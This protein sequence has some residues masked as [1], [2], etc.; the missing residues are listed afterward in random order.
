MNK[1]QYYFLAAILAVG[2]LMTAN[3]VLGAVTPYVS[4]NKNA[5]ITKIRAVELYL[6]GSENVAYMKISNKADLSDASWEPYLTRKPWQLDYGAGVK[7]VY[8]KF[9]DK[10]NNVSQLYKAVIQLSP[11]AG[12]DV[13]FFIN[14]DAGFPTGTVKTDRREVVLTLKYSE[15]VEDFRVSNDEK[16]T[17]ASAFVNIAKTYTWTLAPNSGEKIVFIQFHDGNDKYKTVSKKI[18]FQQPAVYIAEGSL[19]KGQSTAVY[20]FGYDG[21]LHPFINNVFYHSWYRD[22]N[23][24][25]YI[26]DVK[27]R[28]YQVGEPV[29]ARPGTWLIK[30]S[31]TPRVYAV[32]PGC[33]LRPLRSEV[34]AYLIYGNDWTRRIIVLD[35]IYAGGYK[36]FS[37]SAAD[38]DKK[39][40][41]S[42]F[43]GVS[44][45][46][47]KEYGT[48]D[49]NQDSDGDGLSDYEEINS[50][51][52][53]PTDADTDK[54]GFKDG[55]EILFGYLPAGPGKLE[56]VSTS[57]YSYPLGAV[58][59]GSDNKLYFRKSDGNYYYIGKN[60]NDKLF[61]SNRWEERF[62]VSSPYPFNFNINKV[63]KLGNVEEEA[64]YPLKIINNAL[65]KL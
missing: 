21:K 10:K 5:S 19:L 60:S 23:N 39:I 35:D 18:I 54:D 55:Q 13:D 57:T 15:G 17:A 50:W 64:V 26:S 31:S 2:I 63:K 27:L 47:E 1:N 9:K 42:D 34:E 45:P 65:I 20:Y 3:T 25:H 48:S 30:F 51:F 43:D 38:K 44:E 7:T 12:M 32:E 29:C 61:Q 53:D 62:I 49:S 22:F 16:F 33:Q 36:I 58:F 8:A 56:I 11:P 4:I 6:Q 59:I 24:I 37:L 46:A 41:D 28:Q 52:T 14:I 40:K